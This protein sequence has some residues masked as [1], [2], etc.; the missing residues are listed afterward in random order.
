[1]HI[2]WSG[3]AAALLAAMVAFAGRPAAAAENEVNI[4]TTRE[5]GLIQPLLDTFTKETGI[6]TNAVFVESGIAERLEAE[7]ENSPAD[8]IM[9]VDYGML[10]DMVKRGLT[11]PVHSD[12]LDAAIPEN[13]ARSGRRVV[14]DVDARPRHLRLEGAGRRRIR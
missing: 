7:G 8:V 11:Q 4:Y 10:I 9:V 1:M 3:L 2:R 13:A 12:V 14:C 6:K 5:P